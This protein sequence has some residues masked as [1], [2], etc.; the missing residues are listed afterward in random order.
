MKAK[1]SSNAAVSLSHLST[2]CTSRVQSRSGNWAKAISSN[3]PVC[4][5]HL[6]SFLE[7]GVLVLLTSSRRRPESIL[8]LDETA[9]WIPGCVRRRPRD[10]SEEHTSELQSPVH[11]VWRVLFVK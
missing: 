9:R 8:V 10:R 4:T 2:S 5:S 6:E 3:G 7:A 1:P 11:L